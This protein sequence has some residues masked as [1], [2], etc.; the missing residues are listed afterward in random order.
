[1]V[2]TRNPFLSAVSARLLRQARIPYPSDLTVKINTELVDGSPFVRV[3]FQTAG[4]SYDKQGLCTMCNYGVGE[5]VAE[6]VAS[7]IGTAL[8]AV[9]LDA[10][11]TLLVS[12]SGSMFDPREVPD[13]IRVAILEAVAENAGT[14]VCES[15]PARSPANGCVSFR[16]HRP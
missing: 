2:Q 9:P 16:D 11:S 1:M 4:C 8:K 6:T 13:P 14:V 3:W 7:D 12:P 5:T 10:A 15:R